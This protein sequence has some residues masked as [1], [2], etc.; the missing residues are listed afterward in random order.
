MARQ[1]RSV[2]GKLKLLFIFLLISI[3]YALLVAF[4]RLEKLFAPGNE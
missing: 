1:F 4:L 3:A 2:L